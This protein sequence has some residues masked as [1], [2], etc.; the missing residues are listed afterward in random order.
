MLW[1][2]LAPTQSHVRWRQL[3][4]SPRWPDG[5]GASLAP[6]QTYITVPL[7]W[8]SADLMRC[9]SVDE[10]AGTPT[11]VPA[12]PPP[13]PSPLK[14]PS[15]PVALP[16]PPSPLRTPNHSS[17]AIQRPLPTPPSRTSS[18][19]PHVFGQPGESTAAS[20]TLESNACNIKRA[21]PV[22]PCSPPIARTPEMQDDIQMTSY[23]ISADE[24][25]RTIVSNERMVSEQ[26]EMPTD[27]PTTSRSTPSPPNASPPCPLPPQQPYLSGGCQLFEA[28]VAETMM[29]N[30]LRSLDLVQYHGAFIDNGYDDLETCRQIGTE[31]LDAIGVVIPEHR[32]EILRAV[33]ELQREGGTHVYFIL[34]PDY[35]GATSSP[36][37]P[38]R[39]AGPGSSTFPLFLH[40]P[41]PLPRTQLLEVLRDKLDRDGVDIRDLTT[42]LIKVS[43][44]YIITNK[45]TTS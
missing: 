24:E 41:L 9:Q 2:H 29:E 25:P 15:T 14:H 33:A 19:G 44:D 37:E 1:C 5:P 16:P 38:G 40:R 36:L 28:W 35:E 3:S 21:S 32:E 7:G 13:P 4:W 10:G 12:L 23:P 27:V 11:R 39:P 20:V 6:S 31:D 26:P 45:H 18:P 30:W 8:M 42:S 17:R 22:P 43:R 34:D